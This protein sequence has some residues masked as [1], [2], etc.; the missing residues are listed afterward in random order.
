VEA[1]VSAVA[2]GVTH[3]PESAL[4]CDF[5]A[6]ADHIAVVS[7]RALGR[8]CTVAADRIAVVGASAI[9]KLRGRGSYG[10]DVCPMGTPWLQI[11]DDVVPPRRTTA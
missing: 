3:E 9:G 1:E 2:W 11:S 4:R 6:A 7:A 8:N 5:S 10:S